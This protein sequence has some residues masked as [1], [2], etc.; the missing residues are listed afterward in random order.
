MKRTITCILILLA[1]ASCTRARKINYPASLPDISSPSLSS[2]QWITQDEIGQA[3]FGY[4]YPGQ[5]RSKRQLANCETNFGNGFPIFSQDTDYQVYEMSLIE[6]GLNQYPFM[7]ALLQFD[8]TSQRYKL[9]CGGS[10]ISATKILTAAHCVIQNDTIPAFDKLVVKLGVHFLNETADDAEVTMRINQIE[11]HENYDQITKFNDIA[12]VTLESPV[13]FTDK[14]STVCLPKECHTVGADGVRYSYSRI[15]GWG[16][17]KKGQ[18][19]SNVLR[20]ISAEIPPSNEACLDER[21][22]DDQ[23]MMMKIQ[24]ADQMVCGYA[25]GQKR[26]REILCQRPVSRDDECPWLQVGIFSSA[27]GCNGN[28]EPDI[29]TRLTSFWTWIDNKL[30]PL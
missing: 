29:Y 11:I 25:L 4:S 30:N 3:S 18:R 17:N 7:A 23:P 27:Y 5:A 24:L 26:H 19:H 28:A 16:N 2:R 13:K 14:I 8:E 1:V 15:P 9:V 20:H 22:Y 6:A 10:L 12:I 21:T